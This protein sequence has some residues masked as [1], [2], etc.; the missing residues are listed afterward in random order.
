MELV[1][2]S[3]NLSYKAKLTLTGAA[4]LKFDDRRARTLANL[5][6]CRDPRLV[7]LV[8]LQ[9][10]RL[11]VQL[12]RGQDA[13]SDLHLLALAQHAYVNDVLDE[14]PVRPSRWQPGYHD[15]VLAAD[16]CLHPLRRIGNCRHGIDNWHARR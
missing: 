3:M 1:L 15:G 8:R 11:V 12:L 6:R 5:G 16:Y 13:L 14:H 4:G 7:G 9:A 10:G 2:G